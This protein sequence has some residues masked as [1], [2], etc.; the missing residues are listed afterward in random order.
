MLVRQH[1]KYLLRISGATCA[2]R[3]TNRHDSK[4]N[5]PQSS[6]GIIK[7]ERRTY[8]ERA[9]RSIIRSRFS[10]GFSVNEPFNRCVL[11]SLVIEQPVQNFDII[12]IPS[13]TA[14]ASK[15]AGNGPSS[16]LA[17]QEPEGTSMQVF[18]RRRV[19]A[20]AHDCRQGRQE[21]PER[22]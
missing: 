10:F 17:S 3:F 2:L 12:P 18:G 8:I 1:Q 4:E 22:G 14:K 16:Q 21:G 20:G 13:T 15:S 6:V 11:F 5:F 9:G 19:D 7:W